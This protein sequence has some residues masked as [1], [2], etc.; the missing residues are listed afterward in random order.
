MGV[1]TMP[2]SGLAYAGAVYNSVLYKLMDKPSE[3]LTEIYEEW[4]RRTVIGKA[5]NILNPFS[6]NLEQLANAAKNIIDVRANPEGETAQRIG[7]KIDSYRKEKE[8]KARSKKD[9]Y[10]FLRLYKY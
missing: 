7:G 6:R 10:V 1:I 3:E 4:N 5:V 2:G 8:E 9:L